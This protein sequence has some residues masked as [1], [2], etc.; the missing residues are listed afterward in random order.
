MSFFDGRRVPQPTPP[1]PHD[2]PEWA[3]PPRGVLPSVSTQ[4]AVLVHT[5]DLALVVQRF[6][7]YPNGVTFEL[8]CE[9]RTPDR[10]E[11]RFLWELRYPP[12][13]ALP[14]TFVRFGVV[15]GNG[16]SW[17]NLDPAPGAHPRVP[18]VWGQGG[19]G[20]GGQWRQEYW[21]WP[22]PPDGPLT[23][24]LSWPSE[25]IDEVSAEVDATEL[26]ER[27]TEAE[28]LWPDS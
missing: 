1:P 2:Q 24:V 5:D 25:G 27:A 9:R 16:S 3:A 8:L 6:S 17:S 22:L 18:V 28:I 21:V 7:V 19:G 4:R 20:G 26:R 14:D 15:F 12:A 10:P 11:D 13:G 23:F